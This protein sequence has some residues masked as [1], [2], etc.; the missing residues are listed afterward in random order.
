MPS[1]YSNVASATLSTV[2]ADVVYPP[3]LPPPPG[4]ELPY[5]VQQE[6]REAPNLQDLQQEIIE[7]E[8]FEDDDGESDNA[9]V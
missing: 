1:A 2:A 8:A 9:G 7:E 3:V 4:T 6:Q 5:F